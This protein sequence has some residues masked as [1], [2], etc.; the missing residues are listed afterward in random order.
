MARQ[1]EEI[2]EKTTALGA[3]EGRYRQLNTE[4]EARVVDRT[5]QLSKTN[6]DLKREIAERQ[7]AEQ[8]VDRVH[9]QLLTASHEAG[10]AEV[11]TGVLHNVGN[12]LNS[13]N[14]SAGSRPIGCE[15]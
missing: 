12:V 1:V 8:E 13:V 2:T 7:R 3:S 4:L 10:M 9:K 14:V 5:A 6:V 15:R 11:A